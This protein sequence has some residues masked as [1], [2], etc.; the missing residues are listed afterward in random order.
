MPK[1]GVSPK[2]LEGRIL[3]RLLE[4]SAPTSKVQGLLARYRTPRQAWYAFLREQGLATRRF[5]H[6]DVSEARLFLL[7]HS[8]HHPNQRDL[9]AGALI[10]AGLRKKTFNREKVRH[11]FRKKS[12]TADRAYDLL[13]LSLKRYDLESVPSF[14]KK[15]PATVLATFEL[16]NRGELGE[17]WLAKLGN[18]HLALSAVLLE[19][20][21]GRV[22][23]EQII[24]EA[25]SKS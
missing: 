7:N 2:R 21:V 9:L 5:T 20:K 14:D 19:K 23:A 6:E 10:N 11:L 24:E 12:M 13:I 18:P 8:R 4:A 17:R 25:M 15:S 3:G 16:R 1:S 22:K